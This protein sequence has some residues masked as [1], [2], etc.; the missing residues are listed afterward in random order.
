MTS[1]SAIRAVDVT[2]SYG[3]KLALDRFHLDVPRG[4]IHGL[5]GPNGAGK[6]TAV[7]TLTTLL[8]LDC[9]HAEVAGIDVRNGTEVRRRIGLVG[10]HAAVDEVLGGR[11][12]LVMFARL[13]G[14]GKTAAR[15]RAEELL[16]T[17]SLLD[18]AD[19]PVSSWSHP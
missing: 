19:Q 2:K 14:L 12:N 18:A 5:L 16:G 6:S 4:H 7:S 17:F 15:D 1:T 3:N 10:Q 8:T 13:F 11:Q 9:G